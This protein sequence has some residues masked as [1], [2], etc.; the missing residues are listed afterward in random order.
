MYSNPLD[1]PFVSA[2]PGVIAGPTR[3]FWDVV[4]PADMRAAEDLGHR[5]ALDYLAKDGHVPLQWVVG[6]WAGKPADR[7]M[8]SFLTMID[9]A[10]TAGRAQAVATASYW[11]ACR[12]GQA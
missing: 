5:F 8:L 6:D 2:R 10:A 11:H 12:D 3:C 4:P 7:V 1:L 9:I